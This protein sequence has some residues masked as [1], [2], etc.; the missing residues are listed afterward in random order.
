MSTAEQSHFI[1]FPTE[2]SEPALRSLYDNVVRSKEWVRRRKHTVHVLDEAWHEHRISLDYCSNI[3]VAAAGLV[4][5]EHAGTLV[6]IGMLPKLAGQYQAFDLEDESG[7][8][9]SLLTADQNQ[10]LTYGVLCEG[11]RRALGLDGIG[12]IDAATRGGLFKMAVSQPR[13][14]AGQLQSWLNHSADHDSDTGKLLRAPDFRSLLYACCQSTIICLEIPEAPSVQRKLCRLTFQARH[15]VSRTSDDLDDQQNSSAG[16]EPYAMSLDNPFIG[17]ST[18]HFELIAPKGMAVRVARLVTESY[19]DL[20]AAHLAGHQHFKDVDEP[21]PTGKA[22]YGHRGGRTHCYTATPPQLGRS[23]VYLELRVQREGFIAAA[24]L[25]SVVATLTLLALAI[26]VIASIDVG[27]TSS[28]ILLLFPTAATA[29]TLGVSDHPLTERLLALFRRALVLSGGCA[30]V[31]AAT[32]AL[33][34]NGDGKTLTLSI[35]L[36]LLTMVSG[37]C[38]LLLGEVRAASNRSPTVGMPKSRRKI[39]VPFIAVLR[40]F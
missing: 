32:V 5:H 2:A 31:G 39:L 27:N 23:R 3:A 28:S 37:L 7:K 24:Y 13:A 30:F 16:V 8:S 25:A 26:L 1:D 20:A 33:P 18:F 6:P 22:V 15:Y 12:G 9:L 38:A 35:L 34:G 29:I 21:K 4:D 14:A 11:A 36:P 40:A 17:A 19:N 10:R